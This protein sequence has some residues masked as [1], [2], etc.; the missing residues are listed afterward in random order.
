MRKI[1]KNLAV[2][3][4]MIVFSSMLL[5]QLAVAEKENQA[6]IEYAGYS[7]EFLPIKQMFTDRKLEEIGKFYI[8]QDEE[9]RKNTKNEAE[10]IGKVG[11]LRWLERG[12]L[13]ID[14][15]KSDIAVNSFSSAETLL[16]EREQESIVGGFF[17]KAFETGAEVITGIEEISEYKGEGWERILMLNYKSIAYLLQGDRNAYNVTRRAIDLQNIEKKEFDTKLQEEKEKLSKES[18]EQKVEREETSEQGVKDG[19]AKVFA[20]MEAKAE[21]VPSAYVNPFGF[22][23][24]GMIQEFESYQD[25]SLRDNARISYEK[26]LELNPD[27]KVLQRAVEDLKKPTAPTGTRLL[28]IIVADGFVP[29]KKVLTYNVRTRDGVVPLK[30]PIYTPAPTKVHRIEVQTMSG[31]IM[32]TLSPV[33]DVEAICLRQQKDMQP[34]L[35]MR[36]LASFLVANVVESAAQQGEGIGGALLKVVSDV[37]KSTAAPDTRSWMSLPAT[38]QAARLHLRKG[39]SKLKLVTFDKA[40]KKLATQVFQVDPNKH[41]LIYA[42]SMDK[43]L[44]TQSAE[45]LWLAGP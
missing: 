16:E 3:A 34:V 1:T 37:R 43:V 44:Y 29:E 27:S 5:S 14:Q 20:P 9:T 35:M 23:V 40:G 42:R 38:I 13:A 41:S 12:T 2:R 45:N 31:K 8:E 32:G 30:L 6:T 10:F 39:V 36:A 21:T 26:A 15:G 17:G 22:Y 18:G 28:H 11:F 4:L 24:A 19:L 25:R 7:K 33:A